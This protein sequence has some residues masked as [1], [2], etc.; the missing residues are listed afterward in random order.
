MAFDALRSASSSWRNV[1]RYRARAFTF[2]V[3]LSRCFSVRVCGVG[4]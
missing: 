4:S 2:R 1:G 3:N